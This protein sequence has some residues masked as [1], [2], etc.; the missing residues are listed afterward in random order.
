M[1]HRVWYFGHVLCH[2]ETFEAYFVSPRM[3]KHMQ[4]ANEARGRSGSLL[5]DALSY[6]KRPMLVLYVCPG[7]LS[8]PSCVIL[9]PGTIRRGPDT[10]GEQKQARVRAGDTF[11]CRPWG[12]VN[13][14]RC[15]L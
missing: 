15:C 10:H 14:L 12:L 13:C 8:S 4:A 2:I 1:P 9:L 5:C 7:P 11:P 3:R 6:C